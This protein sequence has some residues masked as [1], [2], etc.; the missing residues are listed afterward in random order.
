MPHRRCCFACRTNGPHKPHK[1]PGCPN[2]HRYSARFKWGQIKTVLKSA[3]VHNPCHNYSD[4]IIFNG[5]F[6]LQVTRMKRT[7]KFPTIWREI[8]WAVQYLVVT[9]ALFDTHTVRSV[10]IIVEL[11]ALLFCR[12][13]YRDLFKSGPE[14]SNIV[15]LK[16]NCFHAHNLGRFTNM[17][18][19]I[20]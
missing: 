14:G 13:V 11:V 20:W 19:S 17:L 9:L 10:K 15:D 5:N 8:Y 4:C 18:Q 7:C 16:I 1:S 12:D 2:L 6:V 3:R